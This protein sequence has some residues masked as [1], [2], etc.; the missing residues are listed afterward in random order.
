ML[1]SALKIKDYGLGAQKFFWGSFPYFV[2]QKAVHIR[3]QND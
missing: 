3:N 1:L 2:F